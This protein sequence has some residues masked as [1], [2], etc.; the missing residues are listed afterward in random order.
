MRPQEAM[1]RE[2]LITKLRKKG[3]VI[4]G[5]SEEFDGTEGGI[6]I[7]AEEE[8][9]Q[10]YFDYWGEGKSYEL[11]VRVQMNELLESKGWFAEWYDPGT[12]FI[13]EI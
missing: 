12:V 6:W 10:F 8:A 1:N 13:H 5:T 2:K 4:I 7:S 11:G 9:N 3:L